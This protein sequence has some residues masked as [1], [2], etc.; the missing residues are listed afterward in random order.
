MNV[1]FCDICQKELS[2]N[3]LLLDQTREVELPRGKESWRH[4]FSSDYNPGARK[5]SLVIQAAIDGVDQPALCLSCLNDALR[6]T[7]GKKVGY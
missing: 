2:T 4:A 3:V 1:E 6:E 5:V 7:A